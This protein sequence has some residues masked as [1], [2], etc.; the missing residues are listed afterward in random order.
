V[1]PRES[2]EVDRIDGGLR[3]GG[4]TRHGRSRL[5]TDDGRSPSVQ[6]FTTH[7]I[8]AELLKLAVTC[9]EYL[10]KGRQVYVEGVFARAS[11]RQRTAANASAPRSSRYAYSFSAHRPRKR[12][13]RARLKSP[14]P[15]PRMCHFEDTYIRPMYR[16]LDRPDSVLQVLGGKL[17][18]SHIV[19]REL[20]RV[21]PSDPTA[22]R[23]LSEKDHR[24]S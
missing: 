9:N 18:G 10:K 14:R 20:G 12:P 13:R 1:A 15:Q 19:E 21:P 16:R 7:E 24:L 11:L 5:E 3:S 2:E 6:E 4:S 22:A 17:P 23:S 8:A